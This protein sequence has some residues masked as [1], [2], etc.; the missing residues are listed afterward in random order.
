MREFLALVG[1]L[2]TQ[3]R[4]GWTRY[5]PD[6]ARCES[7]SDHMYRMSILCFTAPA[8]LNRDRCVRMAL[9]HD[10]CEA[11]CGDMVLVSD[12]ENEEDAKT[13][14]SVRSK[15]EKHEIEKKSLAVI[16]DAL[17]ENLEHLKLEIVELWEEYENQST[18]EARFVKECDKLEMIVQASDYEHQ[19]PS[20]NLGEF[21]RGVRGL[22]KTPHLL[23]VQKEVDKEQ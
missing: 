8:N 11:I 22:I 13:I 20:I 19:Y 2:K 12:L 5:L 23:D 14:L 21:Y 4:T 15:T 1:R 10:L 17:P 16:V 6:G 7:V 18:D 3:L 9:V